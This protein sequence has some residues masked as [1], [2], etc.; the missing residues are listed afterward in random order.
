MRRL[1]Y[2]STFAVALALVAQAVPSA[3]Q[4]DQDR[5]VP[6]GGITAPGWTGKVD[7]VSAGF[8]HT[9][10]DSKFVL[11]AGK[12]TLNIGPA[13]IYWNPA[14]TGKGDYTVGAT[15]YE[16][17]FQGANDHPHPY[18]VFIGGSQM[19]TDQMSLVY[20]TAY[21][22]GTFIVRGFTSPQPPA[23]AGGPPV[24][25]FRVGGNAPQA[26]AAV[27]KAEAP[28]KPVTQDVSM[29]VK[30]DAVSCSIN[31]TAVWTGTKADVVGT[32]KLDST[33]GIYGFRVS[34]NLDVVIT[35]FKKS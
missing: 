26:N 13:A 9:L 7:K 17:E 29:S 23:R 22:N 4:P 3:Q 16:A 2:A 35:N 10:N 11:A 34:H 25:T 31:G 12:F 18:G 28:G 8:N 33:D 27:H 14:N 21:G 15:F 32:G 24:I 6:N 20:C 5:V 1:I 30:G 19:G